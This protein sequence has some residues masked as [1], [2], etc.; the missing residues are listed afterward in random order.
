ML[1]IL[2]VV[3]YIF[4]FIGVYLSDKYIKNNK[5]NEGLQE[6]TKF[7]LIPLS[8]ISAFK[9]LILTGS[10]IKNQEFFELEAGGANLAV[11]I[12]GI[13]A[14]YLKLNN[15]VFGIIFLVYAVYLFVSLISWLLYIKN[16]NYFMI[17]AFLSIIYLLGYYA[18]I[19]LKP[20]KP[21][22]PEKS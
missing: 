4:V 7:G 2:R 12:A 9:H 10:L 21:E 13:L 6:F 5:I 1:N 14:L 3:S 22:K 20:E 16:T 15:S 11:F 17:F 8:G 18:Y 19:G